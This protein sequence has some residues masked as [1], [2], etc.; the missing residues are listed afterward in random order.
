MAL[1]KVFYQHRVDGTELVNHEKEVKLHR[2]LCEIIDSYP[3]IKE[4]ELTEQ[5]GEGGGFYFLVGDKDGQ[6]ASYQFTPMESDGGLLDLDIVMKPGFLNML[7]RKAV[8]KHFGEVS[9]A[10]AKQKLKELFDYPVDV[11]YERYK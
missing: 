2:D 11:L 6:H 3:W 5:L 9:T 10:E 4:L 1:V 7:G 8:S